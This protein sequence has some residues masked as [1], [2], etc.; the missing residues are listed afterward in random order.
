LWLRIA[1]ARS[2]AGWR[3]VSAAMTEREKRDL[4]ARYADYFRKAEE[5]DAMGDIAH[6]EMTRNSFRMV[7]QGWRQLAEQV[8]RTLRRG[9]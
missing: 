5:A 9:A 4:L 7:A 2:A 6:G 1:A 8:K 3:R